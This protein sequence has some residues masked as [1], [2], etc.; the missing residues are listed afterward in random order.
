MAIKFGLSIN[1]IIPPISIFA[2]K[3]YFY[4]DLPKGYQI[5]QHD[6]P[7]VGKGSLDIVLASG[8][9]R[10]I[11]ILRAHLEEDAGKSIHEGFAHMSGV[12]LN[13]AGVPLLEIVSEPELFSAKEAVAYLKTLHRLVQYLKICD[14]N[15]QEGS[16]R[17]DANVSVKRKNTSK[18]GTR[19]EIK[20]LNSFRFIEKAINYEIERQIASLENGLPI[21]QET[22][23]YDADKDQTRTMRSK[24]D[25]R[26]YRYFPDPD[27]C[28]LKIT[29]SDIEK[30]RLSL[31]E[32]PTQKAQRFQHQYELTAYDAE[33]LAS[34]A[35]LA[36]YFEEVL[37]EGI[38]AKLAVNWINGD[39]I[40]ALNKANLSI[41]QSP[42]S[43]QRLA[44]LL[45][46]VVDETISG[47][48]A[49]S[50]FELL[51]T[52]H[53]TADRLIERQ[54]LKQITNVEA[55]DEM[56]DTVLQQYPDQVADYRAG[57]EK[58]WGFFIGQMMKVSGG[59]I[60]PQ[61][62]NLQLKKKLDG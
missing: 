58:L 44:G 34:S 62:L 42:V 7:V 50:L 46:R 36:D 2:R 28:P 35:E 1:A 21:S 24:E 61:Q 6:Y 43:A 25:A 55:I 53:E 29:E 41:K 26:D 47:K 23:L 11:S 8:E 27:L 54:G 49:K 12:D 19:V 30:I 18:L 60:N 39:F 17:C 13:R 9:R 20:N 52:S 32:L 22:R 33:I 57:K 3:N 10:T 45:K 37:K 48:M 38:P 56:I 16:F 59:K 31:P 5:T 14:G 40:A 4:P 15:L 51:W